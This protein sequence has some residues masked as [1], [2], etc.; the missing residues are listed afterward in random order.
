MKVLLLAIHLNAGGIGAY[1]VNLAK[2]LKKQDIDV[3]VLSSGGSLER[4]LREHKITHFTL[5]IKTKF[6]FGFKIWK[7]LPV[8]INLIRSHGF[9]IL[10][11]QTRVTQVLATLAARATGV[12]CMSTCHGFFKYRRLSRRLFPCWGRGVIA[13]SKSVQKHLLEDFHVPSDRVHLIYNG[14]E[15]QR[16]RSIGSHKDHALMRSIGLKEDALVIGSIG[17]LSPVKGFNYLITA[18]KEVCSQNPDVRLLIVGEGPEKDALE[19]QVHRLAISEKV[20]LVSAEAPL[21]K[22]F[23]ILDIFC[24]PSVREG[25]GL[26]LMEAMAA[27]R[28]CIASNIGGLPELITDNK[29]GIL[30]S[31][32]DPKALSDAILRLIRDIRLRQ[33][34]AESAAK[35]AEENFSID[36]SVRETK[37]LYE[38]I[39]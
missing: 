38:E 33:R 25:L 30:V 18:F 32:E 24:L 9:Q 35:R 34:L 15:L 12:P 21:E 26:A 13:I 22:Y 19:K 37:K 14:I 6:E 1:T 27:G 36:N 28:A 2:Y 8:L 4:V 31:P 10:H 3:S 5:D 7:S 17:R 11:A 39:M 29:D 23:S 16:Y 20:L